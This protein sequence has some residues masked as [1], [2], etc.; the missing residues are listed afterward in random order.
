MQCLILIC[1]IPRSVLDTSTL[2]LGF[3]IFWNTSLDSHGIHASHVLGWVKDVSH[4][5][6]RP[7]DAAD[8]HVLCQRATQLDSGSMTAMMPSKYVV[9][10]TAMRSGDP[11][12]WSREQLS[13]RLGKRYFTTHLHDLL[14]IRATIL[15]EIH[16]MLNYG[17]EQAGSELL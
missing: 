4:D 5:R 13:E 16:R 15:S 3:Y 7:K 8:V 2:K 1:L 17:A 11:F 6:T 14:A 10:Q 12:I 9:V